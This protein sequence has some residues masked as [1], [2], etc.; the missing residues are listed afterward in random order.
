MR[1]SR[2]TTPRHMTRTP[3][4]LSAIDKQQNSRGVTLA[5]YLGRITA[6]LLIVGLCRRKD[7]FQAKLVL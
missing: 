4:R 5:R 1:V 2:G 3:A 6:L 7:A